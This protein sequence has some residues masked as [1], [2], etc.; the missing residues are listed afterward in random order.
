MIRGTE[1]LVCNGWHGNQT[2]DHLSKKMDFEYSCMIN[3]KTKTRDNSNSFMASHV[4][5]C[6]DGL[7]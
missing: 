3:G 6:S 1:R 5:S 4:G 7:V 2:G